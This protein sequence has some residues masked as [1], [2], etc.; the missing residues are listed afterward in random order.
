MYIDY[1]RNNVMSAFFK[2]HKVITPEGEKFI[3]HNAEFEVLDAD[4]RK[5]LR[6]KARKLI[7]DQEQ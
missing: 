1:T 3:S 5:V 7:S 2:T 4:E 6:M